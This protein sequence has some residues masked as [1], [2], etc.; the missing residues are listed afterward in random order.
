MN[1]SPMSWRLPAGVCNAAVP[2][3]TGGRQPPGVC[4]ANSL[5][6]AGVCHAVVTRLSRRVSSVEAMN[7][8]H[9]LRKAGVKLPPGNSRHCVEIDGPVE[10]P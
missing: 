3:I 6:P 10:L 2:V 7:T 5:R 9:W 4:N 1:T 8:I